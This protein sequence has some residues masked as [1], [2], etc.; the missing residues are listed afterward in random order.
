[1]C[2][3]DIPGRDG[4][5][6]LKVQIRWTN[7]FCVLQLSSMIIVDK[8]YLII[9]KELKERVLNVSNQKMFELIDRSL[10]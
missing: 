10:A 3:T 2:L 4:E 1:M 7:N 9:F 5:R 8:N 6:R